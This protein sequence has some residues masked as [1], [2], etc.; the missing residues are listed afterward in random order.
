MKLQEHEG[1]TIMF[2]TTKMVVKTT[3]AQT[4]NGYT[5]ILMAHPPLVGPAL[6]YHPHGVETFFVVEGSYIFTLDGETIEAN[7]GDFILIPQNAPHKYN[8]GPEGGKVLVTTPPSVE[9]Y[10]LH[11]AGKLQE[12]DVPLEYEF[13]FAEQHGQVFL[14]SSSHWGKK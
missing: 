8:S 14:D 1:T 10:F 5:T 6:H 3:L 7:K 4:N 13:A 9:T 12:G 2:Y 11:I